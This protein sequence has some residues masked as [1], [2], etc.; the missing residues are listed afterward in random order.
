MVRNARIPKEFW[1]SQTPELDHFYYTDI[2]TTGPDLPYTSC[3]ASLNQRFAATRTPESMQSSL[4]YYFWLQK[5]K[6]I[7]ID[8]FSPY[9]EA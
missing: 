5:K 2:M 4:I 6:K 3:D 9:M 8:M 7:N 1:V